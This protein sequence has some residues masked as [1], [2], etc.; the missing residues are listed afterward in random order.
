MITELQTVFDQHNELIRF[1]RTALD[2]IPVDNYSVVVIAYTKND[3]MHQ[4]F[5]NWR[6]LWLA[7]NLTH[8]I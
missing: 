7:E 8:V 2:P 6:S 3:K 1:V 5:M 4:L